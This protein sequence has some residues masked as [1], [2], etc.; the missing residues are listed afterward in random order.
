MPDAIS[1]LANRRLALTLASSKLGFNVHAGFLDGL[2]REAGLT[3]GHIGAASSG[4]YV[5]GLYAAGLSI[6]EIRVILSK[7]EMLHSFFEWQF[8]L[9]GLGMTFNLPYQ[10]GLI[11][12]KKVLSHL[13]KKIG[14]LQIEDCHSANLSLSVTNL[15][16]GS[17]QIIKKGPLAEFIVASCSV[18]VLLQP[19]NIAGN[20]YC[21]GAVTDSSPFHHFLDNQEIECILVHVVRHDDQETIH[22]GPLT[23]AK[24]FA[25]SHQIITDR[26]LDLSLESAS[27]QGKK[28]IV[29]TSVVPRFRWMH[30]GAPAI[31]FEAG[32]QT[33]RNNRNVLKEIAASI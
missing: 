20:L 22:R 13:K 33:V 10:T 28:V 18:P 31:L 23:I 8:F 19:Q 9:R 24:V 11:S 4:S 15:T 5:G 2:L 32:R 27:L 29:L 6:E 1:P 30:P 17:A 25:H 7:K 3:P 21:D 12:G 16:T 26:F 14:N